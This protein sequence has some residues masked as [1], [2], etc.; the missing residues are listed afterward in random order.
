MKITLLVL[1][2]IGISN[3]YS[4]VPATYG[5]YFAKEYSKEIALYKAKDFVMH[6]VIGAGAE[7][8]KFKIDPLAA[9]SSGEL[10]SL[11]YRC[12]EKAKAGLVL[13]FYGMQM[14]IRDFQ[15][16]FSGRILM[17]NGRKQRS[18]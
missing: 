3:T 12:D 11:V 17:P 5:I 9:A 13:G 4:Q 15:F 18:T 7:P 8:V 6:E 1:F 14:I 16:V 2:I 10:T